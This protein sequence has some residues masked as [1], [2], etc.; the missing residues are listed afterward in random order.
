MPTRYSLVARRT[1]AAALA[2]AL[3]LGTAACSAS[4]DASSTSSSTTGAL[5]VSTVATGSLF[6]ST[7]VHEIAIVVDQT[8]YDAAIATYLESGDKEWL[9]A[10][11]TIDGETFEEVGLRLKGNSSL[12]DLTTAAAE[13]PETLPWLVRLDK[14]VDDQSLDGVTSFVIRSNTTQT[15]LNEAVAL[16]L[17]GMA[18]L[19]TEEATASRVSVNGGEESLR[20]VIENPDDAWV[21]SELGTTG[22]LYKAESTG[23]YSYRGDEAASYEDV[24]DVEAGEEDYAPLTDFLQF[25]NESDDETFAAELADHLD[26]DAFASYLAVQTLVDNFDDIDGPGNNSYLQYDDET[27]LMTVVAWDQ[28]LSFGVRNEGE[29]R[30]AVGDAAGAAGA[31]PGG[32]PG[33]APADGTSTDL[34]AGQRPAAPPADGQQAPGGQAGTAT[35]PAAG[36]AAAG[37]AGGRGELG[38]N[39]LSERF[40]AD[41]TF[42]AL[43]TARLAELT[44]TLYTS[45]AADAVLTAWTTVLTEQASDLVSAETITTEAASIATYFD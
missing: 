10:S 19:A 20:L 8:E 35:G 4:T 42:A 29:G 25:I 2:G 32:A 34:G 22:T 15:A 11:V 5:G 31:A 37:G 43:Y 23:D 44:D 45:G 16:E 1:G 26:V 12:R 9:S 24:F 13:D 7:T 6:D 14:Y 38:G 18:G 33:G 41:E 30:G 40:M 28:N 3:M 27:G 17:I 21:E 39:I 36:G